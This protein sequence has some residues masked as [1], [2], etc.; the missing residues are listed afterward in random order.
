MQLFSVLLGGFDFLV[1]TASPTPADYQAMPTL[2]YYPF[3]GNGIV[4]TYN[5][6]TS[7]S[8]A[9]TLALD[10]V[11]MCKIMRGNITHWNDPEIMATNPN[12]ALNTAAGNQPITILLLSTSSALHLSFTTYCGKIDPIFAATIPAN[13][14]PHYPNTLKSKSY[15]NTDMMNSA[16]GDTPY[17]FAV[18]TLS[19]AVSISLPIGGMV[20]QQG[21]VVYANYNSMALTLYELAT[22]GYASGSTDF[23]LTNPA[24]LQAWSV[25][26]HGSASVLSVTH[27]LS[28]FV[29]CIVAFH[30][31]S[32]PS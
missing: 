8:N 16:V 32:G 17:C 18:T 3:Q 2:G 25:A 28:S 31:S 23:D 21:G 12:M 11:T 22:N 14:L 1:S 10:G 27:S 19:R 15:I 13:S 26:R 9:E 20:N 5:L 6:P 7:V 4:P 29:S 30:T 24:T